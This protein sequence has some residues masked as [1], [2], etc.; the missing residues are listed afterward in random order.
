[1]RAEVRVA[2][3]C[4][5]LLGINTVTGLEE[6]ADTAVFTGVLD[7]KVRVARAPELVA[8][9]SRAEVFSPRTA[10]SAP[11]TQNKA[12]Q[13]KSKNFFISDSMLAKL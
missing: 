11:D 1:M 7:V 6:R 8:P 10:D 2:T 13:I 5:A 3:L 4:V 9:L 12:A